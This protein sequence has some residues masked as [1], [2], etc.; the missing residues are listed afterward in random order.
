MVRRSSFSPF[1]SLS[2]LMDQALGSITSS[3]SRCPM[4]AP[5]MKKR[6]SRNMMSIMGMR[7]GEMSS[8]ISIFF[9]LMPSSRSRD[10]TAGFPS[11]LTVSNRLF[12]FRLE[13]KCVRDHG[14]DLG[15]DPQGDV[16][17]LVLHEEVGGQEDDGDEEADGGVDQRFVHSLG[18]VPGGGGL[19]LLDH[20]EGGDHAGDRPQEAQERADVAHQREVADLGVQAEGLH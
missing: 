10:Q 15:V 13:G 2:S 1:I 14:A 18:Q 19:Q 20:L 6:S 3:S 5:S 9:L 4:S 12:P 16:G 8:W 11:L 17:D 7:F